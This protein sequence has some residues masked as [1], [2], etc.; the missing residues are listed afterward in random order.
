MIFSKLPLFILYEILSYIP[1]FRF[2]N[3]KI[4]VLFNKEDPRYIML[5]NICYKNESLH[6]F[7]VF[8]GERFFLHVFNNFYY[9]IKFNEVKYNN[10]YYILKTYRK[11][12]RY[13]QYTKEIIKNDPL[14]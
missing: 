12:Y 5:E 14:E 13:D 4:S 6:S 11:Y 3:G 1:T 7:G 9:L 8:L 10:R 2:R